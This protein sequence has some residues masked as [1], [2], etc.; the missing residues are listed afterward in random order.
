MRRRSVVRRWTVAAL[1]VLACGRREP[2][3]S[4]VRTSAATPPADKYETPKDTHVDDLALAAGTV[5]VQL[6]GP[7]GEPVTHETVFLAQASDNPQLDVTARTD[8]AGRATLAAPTWIGSTVRVVSNRGEAEF[9]T[10]AFPIPARGG[11]RVVLHSYPSSRD[12]WAA[13][14]VFQS[15]VLVEA[16]GDDV[17]VTHALTGY[18]FARVAWLADERWPLGQGA[19][20]FEASIFTSTSI[21]LKEARGDAAFSGTIAPG[22]HDF[23]MTWRLPKRGRTTSLRIAM[24]PHLAAARVLTYAGTG[25]RLEVA[26][27]PEATAASR[28][29]GPVLMTERK[30]RKDD[31]PLRE[32]DLRIVALTGAPALR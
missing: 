3:P 22:K 6:L 15:I 16:D 13:L 5:A 30:L 11:V 10:D 19:S 32:I 18:N 29:R 21:S 2:P 4:A 31:P 17:R 12:I 25:T 20:G 14:V 1:F 24:P 27:F 28:P 23:E 9:F 26:G 7:E 8:A